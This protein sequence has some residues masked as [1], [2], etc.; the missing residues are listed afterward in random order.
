M[1]SI[2]ITGGTGLVGKELCK[3]LVAK[4]YKVIVLSRKKEQTPGNENISFAYWNVA[5]REIDKNALQAAD[6][7]IHLAGAGVMD[8][9]WT[10]DYKNQILSSRVDTIKFILD[11]LNKITHKVKVLISA[12]AIGWYGEDT[13]PPHFFKEDEKADAGFLGMVCSA[14][15]AAADEALHAGIRVC[16]LRTGIVLASEG[17]A[18]KEFKAPLKFGIAG[19]L[20]SG[21]AVVSWI[22]LEDLCRQYIFALE[23]ERMMGSFNAVAPNPVS[24]KTLILK[25]AKAVKGNFYIAMHVPAAVIKLILGERSV[26]ILKSTTVSADKIVTAGFD[27]N[28]PVI[29][30]AVNNLQ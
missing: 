11:E 5:K 3:Q 18:Y 14:W 12:S 22:H 20:G 26:E 7:V 13:V 8:K 23:N 17:G 29:D 25:T 16:K 4:G 27:F 9:K 2:L 6:A 24:N 19:I 10:R 28:Y 30:D 21:K 15:E 1:R